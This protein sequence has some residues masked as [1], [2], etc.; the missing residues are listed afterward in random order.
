MSNLACRA[1]P[2]PTRCCI[3]C[4]RT[5]RFISASSSIGAANRDPAKFP[6][7]DRFDIARA[8]GEH[9]AF[10]HGMHYCLGASLARLE[11]QVAVSAL[12][13]E[14]PRLRLATDT[15]KWKTMGRFR[16]LESL[17]VEF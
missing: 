5:T 9:L 11:A 1:I 15:L 4:A 12:M 6:E 14:M 10:S 2:I 16:G 3:D 13:R 7:P 17:P 8:D